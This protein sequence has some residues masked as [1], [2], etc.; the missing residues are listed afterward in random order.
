MPTETIHVDSVSSGVSPSSLS[1][2]I[3]STEPRYSFYR[4]AHADSSAGSAIIFIYTC[5]TSS[6]IKER[7]IYASSRNSASNLAER[8]V[9]LTLAKKVRKEASHPATRG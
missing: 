8:A 2:T 6:K 7:M 9:G 4:Y 1:S 5:P 3:S